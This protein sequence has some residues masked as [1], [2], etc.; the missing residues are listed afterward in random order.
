VDDYQQYLRLDPQSYQKEQVEEI[1]ALL[2]QFMDNEEEM[3]RQAA[4]RARME[5]E[6]RLS[7]EREAAEEAARQQALLDNILNSLDKVGN[8]SEI[9]SAGDESLIFDEEESDISD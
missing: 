5:E 3:A 7:A 1:I 6:A 2:R 9:I 8:D 4:Q